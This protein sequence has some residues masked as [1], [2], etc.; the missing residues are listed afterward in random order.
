[1]NEELIERLDKAVFRGNGKEAL[2]TRT[3]VAEE[4][5]DGLTKWMEKLD[6]KL[7]GVAVMIGGVLLTLVGEIIVRG[8][9]R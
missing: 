8:I 2:M 3:A 1:M 9:F 6:K 7:T 5:I 4:R